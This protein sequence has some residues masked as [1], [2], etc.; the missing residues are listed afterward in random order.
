DISTDLNFNLL[1][2]INVSPNARLE[3]V[4][5][6]HTIRKNFDPTL[7]TELD[8]AENVLDTIG[9]GSVMTDTTFGAAPF[10]EFTTGVSFNTIL[11]GT[12]QFK[13]G[14]LKGI[15]HTLK[16]SVSFNYI[17]AYIKT[18]GF[19]RSGVDTVDTDVRDEFNTRSTYN[20]FQGGVYG[21]P[22]S[23]K[24]QMLM[25]Y[26][27]NNIF[28]AKYYSKKDSIDKKIKIFD[29]IRVGGNYNFAA[30]SLN[31]S[32][33]RASGTT[34]FFK[35]MTTVSI[36]ASWDPYAVNS[37][38]RRVNKFYWRENGKP[39]RFLESNF[40]FN[41]RMSVSSLKKLF[42]KANSTT[43]TNRSSSRSSQNDNRSRSGGQNQPPQP[44]DGFLKFLEGFNL[45]HSLV[46]NAAKD[47]NQQTNWDIRTHSLNVTV[48]QIKL[49]ENWGVGIGNIGYDF[50]NKRTTYPDL[51]VTRDLHCWEAFFSWQ[52]QRGTYYFTIKVKNAPLDALKIPYSKNNADAFGGF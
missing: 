40:R 16:P 31:F 8:T 5:N 22:N 11:Y 4:W 23:G 9:Y 25:N 37:N 20:I 15:R 36:S 41:T 32:T 45:N 44:Q 17:P 7:E 33:V 52:P 24:R 2:Y 42:K 48:Q 28:E 29:N 49:T 27:L 6:F 13:K 14:R 38:N 10:R 51:R 30:D 50:K 1:K 47:A 18:D 39:L 26:S 35:G 46:F 43:S 3:E 21:K 34:R 19:F 12:V